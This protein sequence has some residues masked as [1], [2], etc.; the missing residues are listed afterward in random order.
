MSA[1][2]TA[3]IQLVAYEISKLTEAITKATEPVMPEG[4]EIAMDAY[5]A[6]MTLKEICKGAEECSG[7][8]CPIFSWCQE[9]LPDN[10]AAL[11]P[12]YWPEPEEG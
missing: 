9:A 7:V 1:N 10:R 11:P 6:V 8:S 12:K 4:V 2:T 3:A 5:A